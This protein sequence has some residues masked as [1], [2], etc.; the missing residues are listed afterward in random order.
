VTTAAA[1]YPAAVFARILAGGLLASCG[2]SIDAAGIDGG[3]EPDANEDVDADGILNDVDNCRDV[4]NPDQRDHDRDSRGD[5]CD[6]C[7]H[8]A[9]ASDTDADADGIGEACDPQ[10]QKGTDRVVMWNGFD[11]AGSITSWIPSSATWSWMDGTVRQSVS[12]PGDR[13]LA[14]P[15]VYQRVSVAAGF[16][17]GSLGVAGTIGICSGVMPGTQR[18]CCTVNSSP[19]LTATSLYPP[20][21]GVQ[22]FTLFA[23][24]FATG[25]SVQVAQ[26]P[27]V[28]HR[29][30]ASQGAARANVSSP[31][32]PTGGGFELFT[33]GAGAAF[34]YVFIVELGS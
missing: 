11:D 17:V 32:G 25:D 1:C 30:D 18:Y 31:L 27:A 21:V 19:T 9:S 5:L 3:P 13:V 20:A 15:N 2:F 23:G 34:D 12:A 22:N 4:K 10:P 16:Q 28:G 7:P 33:S 8:L 29:C 26:N 6:L 14:A 24:T